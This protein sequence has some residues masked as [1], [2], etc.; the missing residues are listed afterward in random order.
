[1][2]KDDPYYIVDD[3]PKSRQ[4]IDI[5]SIPV[6]RLDDLPPLNSGMLKIIIGHIH[7]SRTIVVEPP[8][9]LPSLARPSP[10]PQV[11]FTIDRGGEMPP[12]ANKTVST[13]P[14]PE[15]KPSPFATPARSG[16]PVIP[17]PSYP[18]YEVDDEVQR[19]ST[20]ELIK[21]TRVKKKGIST[22]KKKRT[23]DSSVVV[24]GVGG[25]PVDS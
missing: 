25:T 20:P 17:P 19:T 12:G 5:D 24:E 21:V 9:S 22:G 2:L 23:K 7:C 14:P 6:V 4:N 15:Q 3:R 1:M 13:P 18:A 16:T 8:S 10:S 11:T